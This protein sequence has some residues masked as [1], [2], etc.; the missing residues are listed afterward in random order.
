M[1]VWGIYSRLSGPDGVCA[2]KP[3]MIE[4]IAK[5]EFRRFRKTS[6]IRLANA[7][8]RGVLRVRRNDE[9]FA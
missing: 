3:L 5:S 1:A 6:E 9:G 7:E 2:D 8:E 4:D